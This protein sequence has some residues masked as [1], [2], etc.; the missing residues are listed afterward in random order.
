MKALSD[1]RQTIPSSFR[2]WLGTLGPSLITAALVLGPGSITLTSK[3]GSLYGYSLFWALVL[4]VLFMLVF[5]A[6]SARIGMASDRSLLAL[7]RAKWGKTA[8]VL[9]GIGAFLVTASFQSGNAIGSG[10][11][12]A[13]LT[14]TST[15]LWIVLT[16]V[17]GMSLLFTKNFYVVL[18]KLMLAMVALM[19]AAF[20]LTLIMVKPS[21]GGILSGLVPVV[22]DGSILL[23]IGL[24]GTTFSIVGAFYQS[25]LVREKG[26]TKADRK[27]GIRESFSGI[28]ILGLI[29]SMIMISAAAVLLPQGTTIVSAGDMGKALEPVFGSWANDV[30]LLGLFGASFSSLTGNATIGGVMLAEALD[31]GS[32][33][34]DRSVRVCIM[35]VMAIGALV[36]LIFGSAPLEMIVLAQAVTVII[37]P[38]IG[39]AMF[40][41]ANDK[42]VMGELKN[43]AA[44]NIL[45]AIGIAVLF[46]LAANNIRTIFFS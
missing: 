14:G 29:S 18:E 37:V 22:P 7:I 30:F 23:V 4:S 12:I 17:I 45:A 34:S 15:V 10:L 1:D 41:V 8:S 33:L 36:S 44:S 20:L 2:K 38:V 40:A 9:I 24:V 6:M 28:I 11:A 16:T 21:I 35:L 46:V 25:Y 26:L 5:T 42:A 19:I 3:I 43:K 31:L 32:K 13:D 27:H 39:I